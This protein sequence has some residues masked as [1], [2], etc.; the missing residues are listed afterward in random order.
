MSPDEREPSEA[1]WALG[2]VALWAAGALAARAVGLWW[3]IGGTGLVLGI[4]VAVAF[5]RRLRSWLAPTARSLAAGAVA[6]LL[7][8]G[9]TRLVYAGLRA[10]LPDLA[11]QLDQLY[12][13]FRSASPWRVAAMLPLVILGE[14]LV[15]R[16][17]VL[18]AAR[19]RLGTPL[20]VAVT[21]FAYAAAHVPAGSPLL[22]LAAL[23][24]GLVWGA[25][26]AAT[27]GRLFAPLLCHLV[28][29]LSV[30]VFVPLSP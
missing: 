8:V 20:A 10:A 21:A 29:D 26:A 1:R 14:E 22:V 19:R 15:W 16:G 13:D 17:V 12:R 30:L 24:C 5:R 3:G 2:C 4:A 23:T 25:L 27:G 7:M 9:A 18:T 28:W 6:G 11:P